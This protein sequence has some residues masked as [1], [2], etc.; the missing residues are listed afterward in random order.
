[1]ESQLRQKTEMVTE[2]QK[3]IQALKQDVVLYK[4]KFEKLQNDR[5]SQLEIVT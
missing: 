4:N 2:Q 1:M 5:V 3:N